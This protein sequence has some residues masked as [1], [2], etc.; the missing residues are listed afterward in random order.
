MCGRKSQATQARSD[1]FVSI[2]PD[3]SACARRRIVRRAEEDARCRENPTCWIIGSDGE[4]DRAVEKGS[5]DR[6]C[7][8]PI[9][10]SGPQVGRCPDL[11]R[12]GKAWIHPVG[13][14]W[15]KQK[16]VGGPW[17]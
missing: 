16:F 1:R 13:P 6:E 17:Q 8:E 2:T 12:E 9:Q 4:G 7:P 3:R 15:R 14:H 10:H 11:L 5:P